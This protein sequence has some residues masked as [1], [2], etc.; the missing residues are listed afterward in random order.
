MSNYIITDGKNYIK[1]NKNGVYD[2]TS[3]K[4]QANEFDEIKAKN[5][6]R[7]QIPR[8]HRDK[9]YISEV[10]DIKSDSECEYTNDI[11]DEQI[12][13]IEV[14]DEIHSWLNK[15][16]DIKKIVKESNKRKELLSAEHS[17]LEKEKLDLE[18]HIEFGK[19]NACEG[20]K[21]T[22]MLQK[23]LKR[24]RKVKDELIA[25]GHLLN[26]MPDLQEIEH[27]ERA[28]NGLDS[29]LYTPR[30]LQELFSK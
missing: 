2:V 18:H 4:L 30:V 21:A 12:E 25:I 22:A 5:V 17:M 6:L 20:Y 14:S 16:D 8:I 15:I 1:K 13:S 23:R 3:S 7:Y 28:I 29:R 10:E 24:R 26:K 27:I 11:K 9:F 19:F